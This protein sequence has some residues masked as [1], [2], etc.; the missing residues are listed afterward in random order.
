MQYDT[1]SQLGLAASLTDEYYISFLS[2]EAV[3]HRYHYHPHKI[4]YH[5]LKQ[6]HIPEKLHIHTPF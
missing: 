2:T 1:M 4:R 5:C 6:I 3:A